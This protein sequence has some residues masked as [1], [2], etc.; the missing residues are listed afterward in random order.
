LAVADSILLLLFAA[1]AALM[2]TLLRYILLDSAAAEKERAH[3]LCMNFI[4]KDYISLTNYGPGC[5]F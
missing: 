1:F 2:L 4:T 5:H 3:W